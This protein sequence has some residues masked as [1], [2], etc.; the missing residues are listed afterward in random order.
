[1]AVK[2]SDADSLL[3]SRRVILNRVY[4]F[5]RQVVLHS[6]LC[7]SIKTA[8]DIIR[9]IPVNS[10]ELH[11]DWNI[12]EIQITL[13]MAGVCMDSLKCSNGNVNNIVNAD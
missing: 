9:N 5:S 11:F 8:H 12:H 3:I 13:Q 7:H 10:Y 4:L 2:L 6:A 1:M